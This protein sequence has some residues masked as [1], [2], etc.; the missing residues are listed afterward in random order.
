MIIKEKGVVLSVERKRE[1]M[2]M[3]TVAN[4]ENQQENIQRIMQ[5]KYI[6]KSKDEIV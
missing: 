2:G 5:K 6:G 4:A 3:L 1:R